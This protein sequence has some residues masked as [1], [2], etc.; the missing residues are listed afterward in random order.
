MKIV[1]S[2]EYL[3]LNKY[4]QTTMSRYTQTIQTSCIRMSLMSSLSNS[5]NILTSSHFFIIYFFAHIF[6]SDI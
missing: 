6:K 5:I 2:L 3:A 1:I 4:F